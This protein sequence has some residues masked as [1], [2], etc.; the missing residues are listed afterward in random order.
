MVFLSLF[1]SG[2]WVLNAQEMRKQIIDN[3][4]IKTVYLELNQVQLIELETHST[5]KIEIQS[6][7]EGEYQNDIH[8]QI[9]ENEEEL[10]ISSIFPEKWVGGYDK[11]SAHKVFASSIKIMLPENMRVYIS[12]DVAHLRVKGN[13]ENLEANLKYGNCYLNPFTGNA[14]VNTYRGNILVSTNDAK[15]IA[16]TRL[17]SQEIHQFDYEKYVLEL[18]SIEGDLFVEKLN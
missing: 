16:D 14:F 9:E 13:Y 7:A 8:F 12:A 11:L 3:N 17:G 6:T 5:T 2:S 18:K 4:Q 15:V 10:K 1:L